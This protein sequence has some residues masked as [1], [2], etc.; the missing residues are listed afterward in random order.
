MRKLIKAGPTEACESCS[1]PVRTAQYEGGQ[2]RL[3]EVRGGRT[4][5]A[6]TPRPRAPTPSGGVDDRAGADHG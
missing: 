5:R 6:G 3:N 2:P 1:T 4:S